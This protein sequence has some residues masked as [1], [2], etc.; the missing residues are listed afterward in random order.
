MLISVIV[1]TYAERR[2]DDAVEAV[3]SVLSQ[4]HPE[5]EVILVVDRNNTLYR[6]MVERFRN[7]ENVRVTFGSKAGL[8]GARNTGLKVAR[9]AIIA[10]LDDDAL[11][12]RRWLE[13]LV[14]LYDD[15]KVI[16]A[17]GR[18]V[19]LWESGEPGWFP[20]EMLWILGC[21][22]EGHPEG[23]CDVRNTFG[24]NISFRREVFDK[25]D[26]FKTQIG[27]VDDKGYTAEEMEIC[28][29]VAGEF[30]GM[31]IVYDPLLIVRHRIYPHRIKPRFILTRAWGE[32]R[33]KARVKRL[34]KHSGKNALS[35][36]GDFLIQLASKSF[37]KYLSKVASC[38]K[39]GKAFIMLVVILACTTSVAI[40]Y[41]VETL[42]G[43]T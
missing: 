11:A 12:D 32:G 33:S 8:S 35:T 27:R 42:I 20:H 24:S 25:V 16:G 31:R 38:K 19:P 17:G 30:P 29:R 36:E 22:Y 13:G 21:T 15:E 39:P 28:L 4:T 18:I 40:G 9:G 23:L 6:F 14:R 34:M 37:P 3:E 2:R 7:V 41:A 43:R 26:R 10:F 1:C 5:K